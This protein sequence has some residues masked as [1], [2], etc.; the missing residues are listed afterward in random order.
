[1][2]GADEQ[3]GCLFPRTPFGAAAKLPHLGEDRVHPGPFGIQD[4]QPGEHQIADPQ[5]MGQAA[6][7]QVQLGE[8]RPHRTTALPFGGQR[9]QLVQGNADR[10]EYR[11]GEPR[12]GVGGSFP[13]C[14]QAAQLAV[15]PRTACPPDVVR[16]LP[17]TW[18]TQIGRSDQVRVDGGGRVRVRRARSQSARD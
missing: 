15:H 14:S 10:T 3:A 4:G 8:P 12:H 11:V 1:M 5:E 17:G 13:H 2:I 18:V 9:D 16:Q 6:G 7:G